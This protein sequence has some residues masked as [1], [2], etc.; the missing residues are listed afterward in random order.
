MLEL[1]EVRP[2]NKIIERIPVNKHDL[3]TESAENGKL[4][5]ELGVHIAEAEDRTH[6]EKARLEVIEAE[7]GEQIRA[8]PEAFGF[9]KATDAVMKTAVKTTEEWQNQFKR[10]RRAKKYERKLE[11]VQS[12]LVSRGSMIKNLSG[13]WEMGWYTADHAKAHTNK[14][15]NKPRPY[16]TRHRIKTKDD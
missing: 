13:L 5:M 4:I 15:S 14:L 1:N 16:T 6:K 10:W 3:D 12:S 9:S 2:I 11:G 8:D 7:V